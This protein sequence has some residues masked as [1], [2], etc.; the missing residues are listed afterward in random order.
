MIRNPFRE[1][2][3]KHH[4]DAAI[5]QWE[6]RHANLFHKDGTRNMGNSMAGMFWR[7]F[8]GVQVGAGFTDRASKETLAYAFWRAG[9]EA[10]KQ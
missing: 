5:S 4:F 2:S 10:A 9:Q 8:D 1:R 7:G 3:M 6:S